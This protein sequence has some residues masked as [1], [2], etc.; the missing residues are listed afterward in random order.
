[1][2]VPPVGNP[3]SGRLT[4]VLKEEH[5]AERGTRGLRIWGEPELEDRGCLRRPHLSLE[6]SLKD[7]KCL[8]GGEG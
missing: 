3:S 6:M 8:V 2:W 1:M 4:V 5:S 7:E